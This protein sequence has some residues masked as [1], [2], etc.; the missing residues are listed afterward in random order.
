MNVFVIFVSHL[1][2]SRDISLV[3]LLLL[4]LLFSFVQVATSR[5]N[6]TMFG[7]AA[8]AKKVEESEDF[9]WNKLDE[10][11]SGLTAE[12]VEELNGDFDPDVSIELF[13]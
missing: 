9:D 4:R 5:P 1:L 12:E 13:I 10:L 3:I 6:P 8:L 2:F 11:L 7:A